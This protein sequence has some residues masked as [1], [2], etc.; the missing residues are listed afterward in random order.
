MLTQHPSYASLNLC[1][2]LLTWFV[3]IRDPVALSL[4]CLR[5]WSKPIST[6]PYIDIQSFKSFSPTCKLSF[7]IGSVQSEKNSDRR[8]KNNFKVKLS[9][10]TCFIVLS[11]NV[12]MLKVLSSLWITL[13][14]K[15]LYVLSYVCIAFSLSRKL[16]HLLNF[17]PCRAEKF[18]LYSYKNV[19]FP[20]FFLNLWTINWTCKCTFV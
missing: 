4:H 7:W 10:F 15:H 12:N 20:G 2:F 8:K 14:I 6:L 5:G 9:L 1:I 18:V 17:W 19:A 11:S 13:Y 16:E 3:D